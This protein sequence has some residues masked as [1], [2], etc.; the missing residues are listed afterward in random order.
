MNKL[1]SIAVRL[2]EMLHP[3]DRDTKFADPLDVVLSG[4]N[5][6]SVAGGRSDLLL[7]TSEIDV[8]IRDLNMRAS[9]C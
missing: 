7:Q 5:V 8:Q 9:S 1:Y 3:A 6:G 2:P 4:A